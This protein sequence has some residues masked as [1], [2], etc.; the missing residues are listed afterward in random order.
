MWIDDY[1]LADPPRE[2]SALLQLQ[3]M[4]RSGAQGFA[5]PW[6]FF[7][8]FI[9]WLLVGLGGM[10]LSTEL[11]FLA[12]PIER[13]QGK[14][15]GCADTNTEVNERTVVAFE[16][17]YT[18]A[19]GAVHTA[20]S[21]SQQ[22]HS[23][24]GT[25]VSVEY[26][27][28]APEKAR[29]EGMRLGSLPFFVLMILGVFPGIGVLLIVLGVRKGAKARKLLKTGRLSLASILQQ[30]ATGT[31]INEKPVMK[32]TYTFTDQDGQ[33]HRFTHKTHEIEAITDDVGGERV[34]YDPRNPSDAFL[35]DELPGSGHV[36]P[37]G[38]FEP[39]GSPLDG[40]KMP[41]LTLLVHGGIF[42]AWIAL[43]L[44]G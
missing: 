16:F 41:A 30:E 40:L 28:S 8:G 13:T 32:I 2:V 17:S 22:S 42:A 29:I 26:L 34:L 27:A 44:A 24:V 4:L 6:V 5:W 11:R 31:R 3:V 10:D 33:A 14:I 35:L 20:T 19:Q 9:L 1:Q 38:A 7:W 18:D 25:P 21:Y 23:A 36:T 15:T 12:T 39:V 43:G 37:D